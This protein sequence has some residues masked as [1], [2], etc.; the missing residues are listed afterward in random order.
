MASAVLDLD[1]EAA[2]IMD[3][4]P[5]GEQ[6]RKFAVGGVA[7]SCRRV[8]QLLSRQ[9]REIKGR[10]SMKQRISPSPPSERD[11]RGGERERRRERG[12]GRER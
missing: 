7:D 12:R 6:S 1:I 2:R 8:G 5:P 9:Q 10:Q 11:E 4:V 3:L